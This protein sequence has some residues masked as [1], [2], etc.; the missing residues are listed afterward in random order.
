MHHENVFFVGRVQGV[1]FRY[2]ALQV[3]REFEVSGYVANLPD[4]RV[5]LEV[6]GEKAVVDA[7]LTALQERMHGYI[8]KLERNGGLRP[9]Q[10]QGFTLRLA[11]DRAAEAL[12]QV[13]IPEA[14]DYPV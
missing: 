8:R 9:A 5:Q 4:G 1:G 14:L 3:C 10:F 13:M 2:T 7:F 11:K 6:E 12:T